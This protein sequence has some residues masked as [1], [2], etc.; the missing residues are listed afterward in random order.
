M[1][2]KAIEKFWSNVEKTQSC[3]IWKG[4]L[5]KSGLPII[6]L[7]GG[8]RD[9]KQSLIEFSPRRL[10]VEL[11]GKILQPPDRVQP[12]ACGNKLCVNPSHLVYGDEGRFW[13]KVQKLGIDDC[14]PWIAALDKDMYGK[15]TL[16]KNGEKLTIRAHQYAWELHSGRSIVSGMVVCHSCDHPYCVNPQH[17]SVGTTLDNNRDAVQKGRNPHG[18]THGQHK[19]TEAKVKEIRELYETGTVSYSQLSN[20]FGVVPS[21]IGAIIKRDIWRQVP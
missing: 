17:L 9:G 1:R 20:L 10:S 15:F 8:I 7:N 11:D 6:R 19:L 5:D 13:A 2:E 3:W 18:E 4:F 16:V 14:W 12:L 21:V